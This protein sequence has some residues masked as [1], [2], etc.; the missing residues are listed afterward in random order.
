MPL[1]SLFATTTIVDDL[2]GK[3]INAFGNNVE[4]YRNLKTK[5]VA[6]EGV[7]FSYGVQV[8]TGGFQMDVN[9]RVNGNVYS[10]GAITGGT[11]TG[12]AIVSGLTGLISG[13]NVGSLAQ[14]QAWAHEILD[15]T[16]A[17][18]LKCKIGSGNNKSC[19]SSGT[20]PVELPMP[21][22]DEDI[23]KWQGD[24]GLGGT[25][26]GSLIISSDTNLG[27][28]VINGDLTINGGKK[29]IMT[30][31]I[32]VKGN[33]NIGNKSV[34]ALAPAYGNQAGILMADK[35]INF[36]NNA[37]ASTTGQL[38]SFLMFL[39]NSDC[40]FGPD[41]TSGSA[42]TISNN[43]DSVVINAQ[44]GQVTLLNNMKIKA[45]TAKK[46]IMNNGAEINYEAGL[47]NPQFYSGPGGS[48]TVTSYKEV[49]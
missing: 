29:L 5:L 32:W 35:K 30:G 6:G 8:G 49:E 16:V 43:A 48:Y 39:T 9:S 25:T 13:V 38:G 7:S 27:P 12:S 1:D 3:I 45:I 11:V 28:K 2:N 21:I 22:S 40:P 20:D 23:L 47:I 24:A 36:E 4:Y 42:V 34:V 26:T 10:S 14:D 41:C 15:S 46:V 44:K 18:L 19:D 37:I 33:I 17:G 31:T